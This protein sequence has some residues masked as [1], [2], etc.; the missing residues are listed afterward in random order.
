MGNELNAAI[1]E[2]SEANEFI[3]YI[4]ELPTE[5]MVEEVER[6]A[7]SFIEH[8]ETMGKPPKT[9]MDFWEG[10]CIW[11]IT[12]LR[13]KYRHIWHQVTYLYFHS[14]DTKKIINKA[15]SK[16]AVWSAVEQILK[17]SNF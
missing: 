8:I 3:M 1:A 12:G 10:F 5:E 9:P 7:P 4:S 15:K 13:D 17:D 2:L 11:A 14:K 16:A 6:R